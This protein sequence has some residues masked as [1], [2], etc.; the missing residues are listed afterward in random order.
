MY[1]NEKLEL[2][3]YSKY[4]SYFHVQVSKYLCTYIPDYMAAFTQEQVN[5]AK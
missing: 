1:V 2:I 5:L 3:Y 4:T